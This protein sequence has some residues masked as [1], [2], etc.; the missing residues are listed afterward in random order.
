MVPGGDHGSS[1]A[2]D[3]AAAEGTGA[4]GHSGTGVSPDRSD[5]TSGSGGSLVL[6][7][8]VPTYCPPLLS[9]RAHHE[10]YCGPGGASLVML[11]LSLT[12][13]PMSC[14]MRHDDA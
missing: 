14:V 6:A 9:S 3:D 4:G 10:Q 11:V 1:S 2:L 7:L 5:S 12:N 13:F 8:Q